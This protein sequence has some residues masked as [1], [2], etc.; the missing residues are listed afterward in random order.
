MSSNGQNQDKEYEVL[1]DKAIKF[2]LS[3]V[4]YESDRAR[5]EFFLWEEKQTHFEFVYS[6]LYDLS[7]DREKTINGWNRILPTLE[8]GSVV[9]D[10][11]KI[12]LQYG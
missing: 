8:K 3:T 7:K 10:L 12:C 1:R 4:L 9:A 5:K 11:V 2:T 6:I